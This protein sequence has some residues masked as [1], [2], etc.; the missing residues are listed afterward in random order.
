M[1]AGAWFLWHG[2]PSFGGVQQGLLGKVADEAVS[3]P[4][5]G[6]S[7]NQ[8]LINDDPLP[9]PLPGSI[10][11]GDQIEGLLSA[12]WTNERHSSYMSSMEASFVEQ[13]YV[14]ENC[15]YDANKNNLRNIAINSLPENPWVRRFKPRGACVNHRA[16]GMEPIVDDYGSGCMAVALARPR[17]AALDALP[18][19]H[20]GG[21]SQAA[22]SRARSPDLGH[23]A[24]VLTK[25][26]G[27]ALA[28]PPRATQRCPHD[29]TGSLCSATCRCHH[30]G[31]SYNLICIS[32]MLLKRRL[33]Y[34]VTSM[35]RCQSLDYEFDNDEFHATVHGT[36][37][38]HNLRPDLVLRTLL[39]SIP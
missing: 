2:A 4:M 12:G 6:V 5:G 26:L 20:D 37:P 11:K 28:G 22:R 25:L 36:L 30:Q 21:P 17:G 34:F 19:A 38:Y 14:Q 31:I 7:L 3:N 33:P 24:A 23:A 29:L 39:L 13:L 27:A 10:A 32:R 15:N 9:L 8:P 35:F 18:Q 1:A 16:N